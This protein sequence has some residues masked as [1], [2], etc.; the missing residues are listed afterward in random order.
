MNTD[1]DSDASLQNST[2]IKTFL[3]PGAQGDIPGHLGHARIDRESN[4]I[5]FGFSLSS[6]L[7]RLTG[8]PTCDQPARVST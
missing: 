1:L 2:P 4:F 7:Q 3:E 8:S 5:G 6:E